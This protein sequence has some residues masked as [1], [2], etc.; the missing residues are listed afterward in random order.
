MIIEN[1]LTEIVLWERGAPANAK[2]LAKDYNLTPATFLF[3]RQPDSYAFA[4]ETEARHYEMIIRGP[5]MEALQE[6]LAEELNR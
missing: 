2:D 3:Q 5:V 1:G 6:T 4:T